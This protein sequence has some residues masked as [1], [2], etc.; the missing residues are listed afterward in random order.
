M[1]REAAEVR[2]PQRGHLIRPAAGW[3]E[4]TLDALGVSV[5]YWNISLSVFQY[6][7]TKTQDGQLFGRSELSR[8]NRAGRAGRRGRTLVDNVSH[9]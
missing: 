5:S 7:W 3:C 8:F 2:L 6:P 9:R 1:S 4:E